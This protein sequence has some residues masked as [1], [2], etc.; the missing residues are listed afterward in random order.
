LSTG[1]RPDQEGIQLGHQGGRQEGK[2]EILQVLDL[3]KKGRSIEEIVKI[4][5]LSHDEILEIK[6]H[7]PS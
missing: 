2:L 4:T 5:S 1:C 3:L 7:L 6:G